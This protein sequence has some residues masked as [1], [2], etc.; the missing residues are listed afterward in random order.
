MTSSGVEEETRRHG[1]RHVKKESSLQAT[2]RDAAE[3]RFCRAVEPVGFQ[4]VK[5]FS[6]RKEGGKMSKKVKDDSE[7]LDNDATAA[8]GEEK[9]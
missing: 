8:P 7:W 3:I 4:Q 9:R 2:R 6:S 5:E 1:G